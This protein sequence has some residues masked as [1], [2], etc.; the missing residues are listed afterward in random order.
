[1]RSGRV[2]LRS[3]VRYRVRET[4]RLG[5][6][7]IRKT[8]KREARMGVRANLLYLLCMEGYLN[9]VQMAAKVWQLLWG[10]RICYWYDV[11]FYF[12]FLA[13][14]VNCIS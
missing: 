10:Y 13:E 4:S 5:G 14:I 11:S 8:R 7:Y 12:Q 3:E 6:P 2:R 1:M 9:N